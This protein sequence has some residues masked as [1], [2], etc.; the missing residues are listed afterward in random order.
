MSSALIRLPSRFR[1]LPTL[2]ICLAGTALFLS[3]VSEKY[4]VSDWLVWD[5]LTLLGLTAILNAS[6]V[7]SGLF[8]LTRV[9]KLTR[10]PRVETWVFSLV[11][12]LI[13]LCLLTYACG[14][15]GAIGL[16]S[17]IALPLA[18]LVGAYL[19]REHWARLLRAP[20]RPTLSGWRMWLMRA[21]VAWA[22]ANIALMYL[23]VMTPG[24]INYDA[25]W[26]H[27]PL[28]Q[29]YAREGRIVPFYGDYNRTYP[30]LA[31]LI[32]TWGFAIPGLA[33]PLRW[34]LALHV[35]FSIVLWKIVGVVAAARWM[36]GVRSAH[37]LWPVFF[38]FP[39]ISIYDQNIGG[40]SDH[41]LGV[42][43]APALIATGR[44]MWRMNPRTCALMGAVI[45]G[46]ILTKYQAIYMLVGCS[47]VFVVRWLIHVGVKLKDG[48]KPAP[49]WQRLWKAAAIVPGV[50]L[51]VSLPHF[52]R[53]ALFHHNPIYP[54]AQAVFPTVP[55]HERSVLLF[56]Q[57]FP[58]RGYLPQSE[59]L[60]MLW[61]A[62]VLFFTHS[63]EPH[64][65]FT[66]DYLSVG[67]LFTLLLPCALFVPKARRIGIGIAVCGL[68]FMVW[69]CTYIADRYLQDFNAL[70]IAITAALIYRVGSL[71]P[72]A[73]LGL[74]PL[75][76]AQLVWGAD[77]WFY[78][79]HQR[80]VAASDLIRSGF[81][82][83]RT[84]EQR[85]PQRNAYL[86]LSDATPEDAVIL[87]RNFRTTLGIDRTILS[88]VQSFQSYIW[89]DPVRSP[90]ELYDLY[91]SKGVTHLIY[92]PNNRPPSTAQASVLF[93]DLV[94]SR[95][96]NQRQRFGGLE[97][98]TLDA[99]GPEPTSAAYEVVVMGAPGY[100]PGKYRVEQLNVNLRLPAELR[101]H[102]NPLAPLPPMEQRTETFLQGANAVLLS[103]QFKPGAAWTQA[104]KTDFV[105]AETFHPYSVY[106]RRR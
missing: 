22:L 100:V 84:A 38:L 39:G 59:G 42:F 82:G 102:P 87:A 94:R 52:L 23:Q 9:F 13:C 49:S 18:G 67:S 89:Y 104:L 5:T 50:A 76:A 21:A 83:K 91:R 35:E 79:G 2:A 70:P 80:L 64:Y 12:G 66:K 24:S 15:I 1:S 103:K 69:G 20:S 99:R 46:A 8:V 77:G 33:T 48:S 4:P 86:Q 68:A 62:V 16:P 105:L 75:I 32:H 85:Y 96:K 7:G 31:S 11:L 74:V 28:A 98:V 54:F 29:D 53:N 58:D 56:E 71:G 88:D 78:S 43:A 51:A 25:A 81:E 3:I 30:Q 106:L 97:L 61:D 6:A 73:R 44:A 26:Y 41:F 57:A 47:F 40:S 65:S 92:P 37:F 60:K 14:A 27:L 90:K 72:L 95:P 55:F 63:F 36:L 101:R 10:L 19:S 34:I 45:G 17:V 93:A